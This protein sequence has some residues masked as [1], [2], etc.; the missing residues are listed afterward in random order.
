MTRTKIILITV[1]TLCSALLGFALYLQLVEKM[2]PCPLC[3]MQRYAFA[4]TAIVCLIALA[5]PGQARRIA[6][7][8]AL[9]SSLTGLAVA[10]KHL[11][12]LANPE[13]TCGIDPY[14]TVLNKIFTAR[15]LPTL[16][17]ADGLCETPYPPILGLSIP[18]WA[19]VWFGVC[20]VAL[21]FA[22]LQKEPAQ[23]GLFGR[24]R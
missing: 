24:H 6:G 7:G 12:V 15:L 20:I 17:K 8:L 4:L 16:F 11:W 23:R 13:L 9:L 21:L 3:V 22:L 5:L 14:E 18:A 1:A 10:G 2:L 19:A